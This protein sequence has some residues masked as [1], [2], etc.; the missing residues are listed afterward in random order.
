MV[1]LDRAL[2][3]YLW[4]VTVIDST[5]SDIDFVQI[6]PALNQSTPN[7]FNISSNSRNSFTIISFSAS[8]ISNAQLEVFNIKGQK[9]ISFDESS[10]IKENEN[11]YSIK[12]DGCDNENNEVTSGIYFYKL[13]AKNYSDTKKMMVIK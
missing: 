8:D 5:A 3:S 13:S 4:N 7:P 1:V 11:S 12:W 9:I 2:Y 6:K 10:F